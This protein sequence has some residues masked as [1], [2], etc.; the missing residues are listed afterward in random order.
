[1]NATSA[2]TP[3]ETTGR[4][5]Y[6]KRLEA[7]V[8]WVLFAIA[9]VGDCFTWFP[10]YRALFGS[11]LAYYT[12]TMVFDG[13]S[14]LFVFLAFGKRGLLTSIK[15]VDSII[16]FTMPGAL[17]VAFWIDIIPAFSMTGFLYFLWSF[18]ELF[19]PADKK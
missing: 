2:S 10:G 12:T 9:V 16:F 14:I 17:S 19:P 6:Q 3:V 18:V 8:A 7:I 15:L 1:M 11:D 5:A 13:A 4:W